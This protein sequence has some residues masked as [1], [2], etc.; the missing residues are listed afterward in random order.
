MR[1]CKY[2]YENV[3][4]PCGKECGVYGGNGCKRGGCGDGYDR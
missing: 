3:F 2:I 1:V 4:G